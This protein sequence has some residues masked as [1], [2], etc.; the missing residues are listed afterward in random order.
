MCAL[1]VSWASV[2]SDRVNARWPLRAVP[3]A[4]SLPGAVHVPALSRTVC[5]TA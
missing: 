1:P 2:V 5:A 4:I 3:D